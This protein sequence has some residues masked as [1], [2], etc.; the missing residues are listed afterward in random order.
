M[1][2]ES[3]VPVFCDDCNCLAVAILDGAPLCMKCLTA[4]LHNHSEA[5]PGI[6]PLL[7]RG[8][9]R[10]ADDPARKYERGEN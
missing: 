5:T 9:Q 2:T 8:Y 4:A 1:K 6:R 7:V 10:A 3:C